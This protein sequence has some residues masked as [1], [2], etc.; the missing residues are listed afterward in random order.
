MVRQSLHPLAAQHHG[1]AIR[2]DTNTFARRHARQ[3]A[4]AHGTARGNGMIDRFGKPIYVG[5][6]EHEM[7]WLDVAISLCRKERNAAFREIAEMSGRRVESVRVMAYAHMARR[8]RDSEMASRSRTVLVAPH[9]EQ[10]RPR[11]MES[12]LRG[13]TRSQLMGAR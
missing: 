4:P 7:I 13:P 1:R 11:I 9:R 8:L 12:E 10:H 3:I 6:Q 2:N 5:W